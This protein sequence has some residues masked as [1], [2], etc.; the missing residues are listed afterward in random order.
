MRLRGLIPLFLLALMLSTIY[1]VAEE[2]AN[3]TGVDI[4]NELLS[5]PRVYIA[6]FIQ[7]I[8]GLA[9]GYFSLKVLKYI[10]ALILIIILGV[11]LS[12]WSIGGSIYDLL[13][14]IYGSS[15][16]ILKIVE[17][18]ASTLGLLTIGPI[19][20]GFIVGV[21]IAWVKG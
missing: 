4:L 1:S 9:I 19:A 15:S 11:I 21:I 12:V 18:I 6:V 7:F 5:N 10:V 14:K 16:Q 3:I 17:S 8:L 2:N 13:A 20:V